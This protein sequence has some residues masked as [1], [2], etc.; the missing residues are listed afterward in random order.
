VAD[1]IWQHLENEASVVGRSLA[2][3]PSALWDEVS[4]DWNHDRRNLLA[5]SGVSLAIGAGLGVV[6][7]RSPLI[8]GGV[9]AAG[10][11]YYG[12]KMASGITSVLGRAWDADTDSA[13]QLLVSEASHKLGRE[14]A[15][16]L[17]TAPTVALGGGAGVWASRR[18]SA[19]DRLAFKVT[20]AA[21]FPVRA[22]VPEKLHWIGPGTEN[23]PKTLLKPDGNLDILQLS[24]ML[25]KRHPWGRVE[26]S[27]SVRLADM[28]ASRP[29][30]GTPF[31]TELGFVDR[32]GHVVFHSHPPALRR[33]ETVVSGARPSIA[34]L[35]ATM[36][37]GIIQSGDLTTIYQG[38]AREFS[39]ST[40]AFTPTLR[41]VILDRKNQ[42]AVELESRWM[43]ELR[44]YQPAVARPL[45]YE[46]TLKVL[47]NWDRWW[48]SIEDIPT[49][50]STLASPA[51][52][53]LLKI[54]A[55]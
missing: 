24:E 40:D 26:V 19:L 43:P 27:R 16:V 55:H 45:S 41:S 17:E 18:V 5:R 46:D 35:A 28:K 32:P 37:V 6:L 51:A 13:R 53:R 10:T 49:D 12:L 42:L 15:T 23:L 50:V 54:G 52:T 25:A 47:S 48:K 7:S 20:E 39:A 14:A 2:A 29:A 1:G 9:V 44:D 8:G 11:L 31:E 4:N 36:D 38:A 3:A 30:P 22:G 33:G 21:E 34:D